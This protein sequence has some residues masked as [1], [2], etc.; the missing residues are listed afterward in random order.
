[1][2]VSLRDPAAEDVSIFYAQQLEPAALLMAAFP[3]RDKDIFM[4]HW[5]KTAADPAVLRKTILA[6]GF[7][8]GYVASFER[9]GTREVC[10]WL[11]KDVWGKGIATQA[12][13]NFL[14]EEIRRPLWARVAKRNPAS[15]QVLKKCG[16]AIVGDDKY[17][18]EAGEEVEEFVLKLG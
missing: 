16:F 12:L 1:M 13:A 18:N 10:Y 8:A 14:A 9:L 6:D 5:A 3:S 17:P 4:A 2:K 11:G 15:V 7:V